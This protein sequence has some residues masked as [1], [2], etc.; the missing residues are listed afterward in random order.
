MHTLKSL[1]VTA[2]VA[3]VGLLAL[4]NTGSAW[5]GTLE[6]LERE[7]AGLV[8]T[9][10]DGSLT[11]AQRS[12]KVEKSTR[13]LI[14]LERMALRDDSLVGRN[15]PTVQKAFANYELTFLAHASAE[16]GTSAVEVWM[17]EMGLSTNSLMNA[18]VGRR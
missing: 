15:T 8:A 1:G 2:C 12:Q 18:R 10:L 3:G 16:N 14:D 9:F 5:A 17:R 6:T 11:P 13:R 4:T 7:R